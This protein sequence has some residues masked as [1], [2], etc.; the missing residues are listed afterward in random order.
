MRELQERRLKHA[1]HLARRF[2]GF[3]RAR[4]LRPPE[5]QWVHDQLGSAEL[6][7]LFFAQRHE[8]QRH[9]FEVAMRAGDVQDRIEAALLH[10]VGKA[11][12]SLG[13]VGRSCATLWALTGLKGPDSWSAYVEHGERGAARLQEAGA[14]QLTVAFARHHPGPPPPGVRSEDWHALERADDV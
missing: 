13:A 1:S 14:G 3:L 9:A 5:Q 10:D 2:F 8:D 6:R 7:A 12:V 4:P 11:D